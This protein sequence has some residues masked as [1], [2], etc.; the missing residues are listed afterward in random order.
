MSKKLTT[1]SPSYH[2]FVED[3]VL[4]HHQLNEL[5]EYFE[6]QDRLSRICLSGVGLVCGFEVSQNNS[7]KAITIPMEPVLQP[8]EIFYIYSFPM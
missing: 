1:I 7:T 2:S 8:M 3:Q 5:I 4:T 6:D